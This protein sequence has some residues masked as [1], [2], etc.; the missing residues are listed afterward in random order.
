[1]HN[2]AYHGGLLRAYEG[3]KPNE[4][5]KINEDCDAARHDVILSERV[6]FGFNREG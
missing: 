6:I 1:V 2:A 3:R 5:E 4:N